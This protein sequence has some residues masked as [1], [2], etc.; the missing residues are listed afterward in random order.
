MKKWDEVF[1]ALMRTAIYSDF[2]TIETKKDI[3]HAVWEEDVPRLIKQYDRRGMGENG[4]NGFGF[5]VEAFA[6]RSPRLSRNSVAGARLVNLLIHALHTGDSVVGIGRKLSNPDLILVENR[7]RRSVIIGI[8]EIKS[9]VGALS[10]RIQQV[11]NFESGLRLLLA[12]IKKDKAA[13][14]A[15]EY[16]AL[17][18]ITLADPI[19][20][21]LLLPA[22]EAIKAKW[23]PMG[24]K[25]LEIEF[26]FD[27]L[28]FIA[29]H[30]WPDFR[31]D[32]RPEEGYLP[33]YEREFLAKLAEW[34]QLRLNKIFAKT[35]ITFFPTKDY[36]MYALATGEL[37]LADE[38]VR[39]V[40]ACVRE[41]DS[42]VS[43][44]PQLL[45]SAALSQWER[46][47]VEYFTTL[48]GKEEK[49]Q[50]YILHFLHD[51]RSFVARLQK[52]LRRR[53]MKAALR[54]GAHAFDLLDT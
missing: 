30:I 4:E 5:F 43:F 16:L 54:N 29:K 9:S 49:I 18:K 35:T 46:K 1:T 37:P 26:S 15:T 11:T 22:G 10:E 6:K 19:K 12:K 7:G 38:Q 52:I 36:L 14:V 25:V 33:R 24:W 53:E 42:V 45:D 39:T 8:G 2:A 40:A 3:L 48:W 44:P 23:L 20:K 34:G 32:F 21:V 31:K 17:K 50:K 41:A 28:I 47:F 27:E 51:R 13:G